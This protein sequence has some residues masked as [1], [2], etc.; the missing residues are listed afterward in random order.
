MEISGIYSSLQPVRRGDVVQLVFGKKDFVMKVYDKPRFSFELTNMFSL[1]Q[2]AVFNQHVI[3]LREASRGVVIVEAFIR[4][5]LQWSQTINALTIYSMEMVVGNGGVFVLIHGDGIIHLPN[6]TNIQQ[7]ITRVLVRFTLNGQMIAYTTIQGPDLVG[8]LY[9][10]GEENAAI[11]GSTKRTLVI[12]G[13]TVISESA[14]YSFAV[15]LSPTLNPSE[16]LTTDNM[17]IV[18]ISAGNGDIALIEEIDGVATLFFFNNNDTSWSVA[19]GLFEVSEIQV[20][21]N[22]IAVVGNEFEQRKY[23]VYQFNFDG[24][25][26]NKSILPFEGNVIDTQLAYDNN[27]FL[28][29]AIIEVEGGRSLVEYNIYDAIIVWSTPVL[30]NALLVSGTT[31]LVV[32]GS[33]SNIQAYTKRLPALIGA[34]SE[35]LWPIQGTGSTGSTG[36]TGRGCPTGFHGCTGCPECESECTGGFSGGCCPDNILPGCILPYVVR[37]DFILTKAFAPVIPGQEY[38]LDL[39]NRITT[40][41]MLDRYIGTALDFE[42]VLMLATGSLA[43]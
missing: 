18:K 24:T 30:L 11:Y 21:D 33:G 34:V 10:Y 3:T 42:R 7:G 29:Y 2:I 23:V 28:L 38:F 16:I 43:P 31:E 1:R 4:N 9:D 14:P 6:G 19:L 40:D 13:A 37:V 25:Q 32:V 26:I 8:V 22:F 15:A 17:S 12:N 36:N 39:S 20:F 35:V 27:R 41:E 5:N